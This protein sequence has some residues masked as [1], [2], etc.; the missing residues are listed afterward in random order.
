MD[1]VLLLTLV[2]AATAMLAG[3]ALFLPSVTT[4][5]NAWLGRTSAPV[6]EEASRRGQIVFLLLCYAAPM[7]L[8]LAARLVQVAARGLLSRLADREE[9]D[10]RFR[11]E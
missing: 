3:Y 5:L 8:S 2:A 11:M 4:E 7:V 6:A 9:D 1:W 10:P